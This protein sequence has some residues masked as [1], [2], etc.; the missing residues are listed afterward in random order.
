MDTKM[1]NL[2]LKREESA[3]QEKELSSLN[4]PTNKKYLGKS[5]TA[6]NLFSYAYFL[7]LICREYEEERGQ[8]QLSQL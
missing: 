6:L 8:A 7:K 1:E 3:S 2:P 4:I 5:L